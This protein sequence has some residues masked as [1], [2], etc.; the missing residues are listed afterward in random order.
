MQL[1]FFLNEIRD[2][3]NF[4]CE[5]AYEKAKTEM[6]T[7]MSNFRTLIM[8]FW[9][10][11]SRQLAAILDGIF[12]YISAPSLKIKGLCLF[13]LHV[14]IKKNHN[15]TTTKSQPSNASLIKEPIQNTTAKA[16][17]FP[18]MMPICIPIYKA[19]FCYF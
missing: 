11:L 1:I 2:S 13:E 8:R 5:Y 7:Y 17:R 12:T 10:S 6:K 16:E 15:K 3:Q 18:S 19:K 4:E 14:V 9:L